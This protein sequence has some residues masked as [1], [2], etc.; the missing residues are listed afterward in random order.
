MRVRILGRRVTSEFLELQ[1]AG[2][3]LKLAASPRYHGLCGGGMG[4]QQGADKDIGIKH[5]AHGGA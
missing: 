3:Q 5:H 1:F 4:Q 2:H